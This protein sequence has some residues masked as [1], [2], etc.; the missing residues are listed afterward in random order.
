MPWISRADRRGVPQNVHGPKPSL[1][2]I[3]LPQF[4]QFG[5]AANKGWRVAMQLHFRE[6]AEGRRDVLVLISRVR[7]AESRAER[8]VEEPC[9]DWPPVMVT[10][11]C[12]GLGGGCEGVGFDF[13]LC[14]SDIRAPEAEGGGFGVEDW[15]AAGLGLREKA[16]LGPGVGV[17]VGLLDM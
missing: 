16:L 3:T 2:Q 5:A 12:L 10:L 15:V 6:A 1:T 9:M 11:V 13:G 17:G 14:R 4:R 7:I 8:V